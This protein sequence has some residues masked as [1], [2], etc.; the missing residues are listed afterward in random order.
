[1]KKEGLQDYDYY[2]DLVLQQLQ[3]SI[4]YLTYLRGFC[5]DQETITAVENVGKSIETSI[6]VLNTEFERLELEAEKN[7]TPDDLK[8]E[9]DIKLAK[10]IYYEAT[11]ENLLLTDKDIMNSLH[12]DLGRIKADL[13]T[14]NAPT[15]NWN[16]FLTNDKKE[17]VTSMKDKLNHIKAKAKG[18]N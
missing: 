7:K 17:W 2:N 18:E 9:A 5:E 15:P 16:S 11:G 4:Y 6:E 1:M 14:Y 10:K 13:K 8:R 3:T 12:E